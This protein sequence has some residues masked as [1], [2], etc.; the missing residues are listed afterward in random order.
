MGIEATTK[1]YCNFSAR[2]VVALGSAFWIRNLMIYLNIVLGN[3]HSRA[4][5][6]FSF[7]FVMCTTRRRDELKYS[8]MI[9]NFFNFISRKA[10]RRTIVCRSACFCVLLVLVRGMKLRLFL[11]ILFGGCSFSFNLVADA[12]KLLY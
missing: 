7:G 12:K 4:F 10:K 11:F 8:I 1:K 3:K 5:H 2:L 9:R 6:L